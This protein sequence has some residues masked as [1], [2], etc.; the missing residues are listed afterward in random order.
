VRRKY[1]C[2]YGALLYVP[3]PQLH[4]SDSY[5]F[6]RDSNQFS[7][8]KCTCGVV[9]PFLKIVPLHAVLAKLGIA[10]PQLFFPQVAHL[11]TPI[12]VWRSAG[13]YE[14]FHTASKVLIVGEPAPVHAERLVR[15]G[16]VNHGL[17][18]PIAV[19]VVLIAVLKFGI[20]IGHA[21]R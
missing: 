15:P 18:Y 17:F 16:T 9:S 5:V 11:F 21:G 6:M 1:E 13:N 3:N 8:S 10:K 14:C 7:R 2:A 19:A 4:L 20:L 12:A